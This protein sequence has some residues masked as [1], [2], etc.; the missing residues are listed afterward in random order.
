MAGVRLLVWLIAFAA[1]WWVVVAV[2]TA[3]SGGQL[4]RAASRT[5][6]K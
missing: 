2:L 1:A 3:I 6:M 5:T 4:S